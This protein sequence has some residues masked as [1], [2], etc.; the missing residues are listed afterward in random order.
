MAPERAERSSLAEIARGASSLLAILVVLA[1]VFALR[2]LRSVVLPLAFALFL[3][4]LFWPL[5]R[6][7]DARVGRWPAL[8]VTLTAMSAALALFV[9]G[10]WLS[11]H[12][13]GDG[14]SA[15]A[16][17]LARLGDDVRAWLEA[18]GIPAAVLEGGSASGRAIGSAALDASRRLFDVGGAIV[19][20]VGFLVLALLEVPDYRA[21]LE[22]LE[23][24]RGR[25]R[26]VVGL[27]HA[28]RAFQRYVVVRTVVG[29]ITG[30]AVWLGCALLGVELAFVWGFSSFVLNYVPT[31]GSVV[32]VIPPPLF[33]WA[34]S[35]D[36]DRA[37][38]VFAAVGGIQI[39][40]GTV[41][42]PRLQ[43]R[44]LQLSP[45]VV[46][47]SIVLWGWIWGI[48]GAFVGVPMTLVIA[49]LCRRYERT[50]WIA[51]LL[52]DEPS[53]EAEPA[54]ETTSRAQDAGSAP[55]PG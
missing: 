12:M 9:A 27:R 32:A 6:A 54:E 34:E 50:R 39:V 44:Y 41:V 25:A 8:G 18:R 23:R 24:E 31:L 5:Q 46:L 1:G 30:G 21:K 51:D 45:L 55:A 48:A 13:I 42:D 43:G 10:V 37:L 4:A 49:L 52:T 7:L 28:S 17:R 15:Y 40:L 16:D 53:S 11:L 47:L 38:L 26:L 22:R 36:P 3:V 14:A 19:L 35:G 20:T 33:A 2:E 29:L